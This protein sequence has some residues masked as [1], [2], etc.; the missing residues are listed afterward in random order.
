TRSKYVYDVPQLFETPV[1]GD[2]RTGDLH[3]WN[4][5]RTNGAVDLTV[6]APHLPTLLFGYRLYERDGASVS[7][8]HLPAGDTFL[9]HAPI[10]DVTHA[11]KVGADFMLL[12]TSVF[13]Q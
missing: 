8:L 9:V 11:G 7:T 2:L 5:V 4:F 3:Q 13:V 12:D 6:R 10:D 1:P